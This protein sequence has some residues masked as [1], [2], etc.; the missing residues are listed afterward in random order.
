MLSSMGMHVMV[1]SNLAGVASLRAAGCLV[2][3]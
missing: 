3:A 1:E 2:D